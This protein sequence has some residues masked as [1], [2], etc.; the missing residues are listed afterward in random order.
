MEGVESTTE[1]I[2]N[3][4]TSS[5]EET[6]LDSSRDFER[7]IQDKEHESKKENEAGIDEEK[8]E[9]EIEDKNEKKEDPLMQSITEKSGAD[10]EN[11]KVEIDKT[12]SAKEMRENIL[13][14]GMNPEQQREELERLDNILA[15][16]E[17]TY[18]FPDYII[19]E[20]EEIRI[21]S[22]AAM[23]VD[24]EGNIRSLIVFVEEIKEKPEEKPTDKLDDT[25]V[26]EATLTEV[27]AV[28]EGVEQA[29]EI[30]QAEE[31]NFT[32]SEVHY[33][34]VEQVISKET[35]SKLVSSDE[36]VSIDNTHYIEQLAVNAKE[37]TEK[38]ITERII[39]LLKE[40]PQAELI[41]EANTIISVSEAEQTFKATQEHTEPIATVEEKTEKTQTIEER[42][43]ELLR[44][45][46]EPIEAAFEQAETPEVGNTLQEQVS[47]NTADLEIQ[48]KGHLKLH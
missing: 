27:E 41:E 46:D 38:I 12:L 9:Q 23:K 24:G 43:I 40:E 29:E 44:D 28:D 42:I 25:K 8:G 4:E 32:T 48:T 26:E 47:V 2:T 15:N 5:E 30:I 35:Q 14:S 6:G 39:D 3:S 20:T 33:A 13:N 36:N 18:M 22:I 11:S 37:A 31:Q 16:P 10:A 17:E 21:T 19:K 7:D 1:E 34:D 45:D